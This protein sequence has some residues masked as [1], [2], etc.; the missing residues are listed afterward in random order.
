MDVSRF[1]L[2]QKKLHYPD[3]RIRSL[4]ES[5]GLI[6]DPL[7]RASSSDYNVSSVWKR[8]PAE[9]KIGPNLCVCLFVCVFFSDEGFES[10]RDD[11]KGNIKK[12]TSKRGVFE[13]NRHRSD[14]I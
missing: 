5:G 3:L 14:L 9:R 2:D 11:F 1:F 4:R 12:N 13:L 8:D 10:A 6:R 7:L